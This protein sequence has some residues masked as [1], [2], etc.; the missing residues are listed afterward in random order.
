LEP[1]VP[2]FTKVNDDDSSAESDDPFG[3]YK[4]LKR[5]ITKVAS[6]SVDPQFPP[7]FTPDVVEVNVV[8]DANPIPVNVAEV[9]DVPNNNKGGSSA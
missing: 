6:E 1:W 9:N 7:G 3:I 5:D 4:I 2:K 8:E